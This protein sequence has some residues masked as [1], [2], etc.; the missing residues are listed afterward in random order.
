MTDVKDVPSE[1][2]KTFSIVSIARRAPEIS[3]PSG[4]GVGSFERAVARV[5]PS[6]TGRPRQV[7][8]LLPV[9][10]AALFMQELAS[11]ATS[12][13]GLH[14]SVGRRPCLATFILLLLSSASQLEAGAWAVLWKHMDECTIS[15]I[16]EDSNVLT[17]LT[18]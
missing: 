15:W 3:S 14:G 10:E 16:K 12:N 9:L 13:L 11:E 7:A 2:R 8:Q 1:C 18:G 4:S 17:V 5:K 6:R